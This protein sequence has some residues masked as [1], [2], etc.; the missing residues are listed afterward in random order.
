VSPTQLFAEDKPRAKGKVGKKKAT[1]AK[2]KQGAKQIR[3]ET[4]NSKPEHRNTFSQNEPREPCAADTTTR[5]N[6][7]IKVL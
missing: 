4:R 3:Q 7:S 6:A 2:S 1:P 5:E